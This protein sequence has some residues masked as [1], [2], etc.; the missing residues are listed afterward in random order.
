MTKIILILAANPLNTAKLRVNSEYEAIKEVFEENK[1]FIVESNLVVTPRNLSKT[2]SKYKPDIVHFIGHGR[3]DG[4][5]LEDYDSLKKVVTNKGFIGIFRHFDIECLYLNSC[6]SAKQ[7][8]EMQ[9]Y[10]DYSIGM[11]D[12]INDETAKEFAIAFYKKLSQNER[13]QSAFDFARSEIE[14]IGLSGA[15]VPKP[16]INYG[17]TKERKFNRYFKYFLLS[18]ISIIIIGI[19]WFVFDKS[20]KLVEEPVE[21]VVKIT[22]P[23]SN[24]ELKPEN[25]SYDIKTMVACGDAYRKGENGFPQNYGGA[26]ELYEK[27]ANEG[28]PDALTNLGNMYEKGLGVDKNEVEAAKL[29]E[30]A[31]TDHNHSIASLKLG[32]LYDDG[33]G[34][35]KDISKARY[36]FQRAADFHNLSADNTKDF[37]EQLLELAKHDANAQYELGLLYEQGLIVAKDEKEAMKWFRKAAKQGHEKAKKFIKILNSEKKY[38]YTDSSKIPILK[39]KG[40]LEVIDFLKIIKNKP[41]KKIESKVSIKQSYTFPTEKMKKSYMPTISSEFDLNIPI[42]HYEAEDS[43]H[44]TLELKFYSV[45]KD[46]TILFEKGD[47]VLIDEKDSKHK[48]KTIPKLLMPTM[49]RKF[50]IS[51]PTIYYLGEKNM[52]FS[53]ELEFYGVTKKNN[54]L[55]EVTQSNQL[56][57]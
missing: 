30:R 24:A 54:E 57:R 40:T 46:G 32:K 53:L 2:L 23:K 16:F 4:V 19:A 12:K 37:I 10:I 36:F 51:I 47:S 22:P 34:V 26:V 14:L 43:K 8:Q 6:H 9:E 20:G 48:I 45:N 52:L 55:F 33:R 38:L 29:Y 27:A 31:A 3:E 44:I 1:N 25:C 41:I 56:S 39:K 18:L 15:D 7:A 42:I 28:N 50:V 21:P 35:E 5:V 13:Y 17:I 49:S 11:Q